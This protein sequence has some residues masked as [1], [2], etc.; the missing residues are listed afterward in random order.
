MQRRRFIRVAASAAGLACLPGAAP[1]PAGSFWRWRGAAL[2]AEARV[3]LAT[4]DRV[5]ARRLVGLCVAEIDRLERV[6][7][8]HRADSALSC[9]NRDGELRDPPLELT[10]VLEAAAR[11]A[12]LT[13]GAFDPTVQPL[14]RLHARHFASGDPAGPPRSELER[15][16]PLVDHRALEA[17]PAWARFARPGM[18]A[19]LNG[20]AQGFIADRLAELLR[21]AGM[22]SAFVDAGEIRALG[23]APGGSGWPVRAGT[24]GPLL[25][26]ADSAIATSSPAA[27]AFDAAGRCGHLLD[28]AT[29]R[30]SPAAVEVTVVAES[31]MLADALSTA[32][33]VR[34]SLAL[35][36]GL[37]VREIVRRPLPARSR[38]A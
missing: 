16:R 8:L 35:P 30:P 18:A 36:A 34:P 32:L 37:G 17:G 3:E 5:L 13:D 22:A 24:D 4:E 29:L 28:P 9:L 25:A 10:L 33:A 1:L 27:F 15:L 19:T 31:A 2:G 12:A 11:V 23:T 7:S 6:F 26:A 38:S 20:I 14:W 21:D